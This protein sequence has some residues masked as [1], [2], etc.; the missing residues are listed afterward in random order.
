MLRSRNAVVSFPGTPI[1]FPSRLVTGSFETTIGPY[2]SP[3]L[4]PQDM[5][6]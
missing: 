6:L 4:A 1:S 5:I 3:M 2:P